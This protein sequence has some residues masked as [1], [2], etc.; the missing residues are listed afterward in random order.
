MDGAGRVEVL[1]C[2]VNAY[3]T[4]QE[5]IW[6]E[7]EVLAYQPDLVLLQYYVNDTAARGL[8]VP[9][10]DDAVL[11]F[12][13]P[14]RSDWLARLRGLSRFADLVLDGLYRRRGLA[15]YSEL[16]T[17]LYEPGH[18]GWVRVQDALRR[19]R[20]GLAE[21]DT[22]FGLVLYPFLVE[23]HGTLTSHDAFRIV[24][25][26][27][28]AEGIPYLDTEPAFLAHDVDTLRVSPHDYHGNGQ[29]HAI[30]AREV[31]AWSRDQGWLDP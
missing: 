3:D 25:D 12:A 15:V 29:A 9:A 1:N 30:F 16:R 23:R 5:V 4:L 27:C 18:P 2:G 31:A 17:Q 8:P 28:D 24:M 6:M 26:F 22:A 21:R 14:H 7:R 19:A 20:D 10:P 11:A 13:S